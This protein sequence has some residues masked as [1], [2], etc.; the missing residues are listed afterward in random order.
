MPEQQVDNKTEMNAI[1]ADPFGGLTGGVKAAEIIPGK[2]KNYALAI[3][4]KQKSGKSWFATSDNVDK[5]VWVADFD[6]RSESI[7]GRPNVYVKSFID[8]SQQSPEAIVNLEQDLE[9]FKYRRN[10]KNLPIPDVFVLDSITYMKKALENEIIR[11]MSKSKGDQNFARQ[12]GTGSRKVLIAQ[13]WDMINAV[14]GY[15]EYFIAEF[16][17]LGNLICVFHERPEKDQM[18]STKDNTVF[19]GQYSVDPFYLNSLLSVFSEVMRIT[20][21]GYGKYTVNT[22]SNNEFNGATTWKVDAKEEP[23]IS[24]MLKKHFEHLKKGTKPVR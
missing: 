8:I 7:S 16:R 11:A 18:H 6:N 3:V 1:A 23:N 13:G 19:T 17:L 4:G 12:I 21:D 2:T 9:L 22:T 20:V 14:R 15:L 24:G 10:V 5:S